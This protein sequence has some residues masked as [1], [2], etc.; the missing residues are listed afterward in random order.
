MADGSEFHAAGAATLKPREAKVVRSRG[1]DSLMV[2]M[3]MMMMMMMCR[4]S[5]SDVIDSVGDDDDDDDDDV[6]KSRSTP[7]APCSRH[8]ASCAVPDVLRKS[9]A[10][11][12][13]SVELVNEKSASTVST[14]CL[15]Q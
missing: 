13:E 11:R 14:F 10:E 12:G 15:H 7:V 6:T 1:T 9:P 8:V 3:M 5:D 4:P 2:M